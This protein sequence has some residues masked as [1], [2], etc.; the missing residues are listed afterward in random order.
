MHV[1]GVDMAADPG[2]KKTQ[3]DAIAEIESGV[4]KFWVNVG[5][6]TV[7]VLSRR[8]CRGTPT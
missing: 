6:R 3:A 7:E 8:A 2:W 1:G 5:G 4:S